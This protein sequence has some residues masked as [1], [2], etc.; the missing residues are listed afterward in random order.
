MRK[1]RKP[2]ALRNQAQIQPPVVSDD[3][4]DDDPHDAIERELLGIWLSIS[5]L[6]QLIQ[7]RPM[8]SARRVISWQRSA[9]KKATHK[10]PRRKAA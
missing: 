6:R 2:A 3:P 10:K 1:H 4:I 8:A 7:D 9:A 5:R